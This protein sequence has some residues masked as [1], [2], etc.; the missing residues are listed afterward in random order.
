MQPLV[1]TR[2]AA[3]RADIEYYYW[4]GFLVLFVAQSLRHGFIFSRVSKT[5]TI[6]SHGIMGV[7]VNTLIRDLVKAVSLSNAEQYSAHSLR[8]GFA[9]E[10]ARLG[11]SML[12]I[13][14]CG[15]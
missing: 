4:L 5:G 14:K 2:V 11:A 6:S 13:Q 9:T 12:A 8:R 15:R 7:Y 3:Y 10:V 1:T